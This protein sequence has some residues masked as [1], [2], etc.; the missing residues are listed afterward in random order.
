MPRTIM[1]VRRQK[2]QAE[3]EHEFLKKRTDPVNLF[4]YKTHR[5]LP[6]IT[7]WQTLQARMPAKCAFAPLAAAK[8]ALTGNNP[9]VDPNQLILFD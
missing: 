1:D 4:S 5:P 2:I 8:A 6:A 3:Q 7:A 9:V